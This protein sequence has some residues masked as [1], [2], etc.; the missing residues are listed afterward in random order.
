[1]IREH[2]REEESE[3]YTEESETSIS[4]LIENLQKSNESEFINKLINN[5]S[6][7]NDFNE[8]IFISMTEYILKVGKNLFL[9]EQSELFIELYLEI[10]EY[11]KNTA[12]S[13][14]KQYNIIF[15]FIDNI[16]MD[17]NINN[18]IL[19][20]IQF[21]DFFKIEIISNID[22][23]IDKILNNKRIHIIEIITYIFKWDELHEKIL[24][25]FNYLAIN[26]SNF[27]VSE[28]IDIMSLFMIDK[29]RCDFIYKNSLLV[30]NI[31]IYLDTNNNLDGII[32]HIIKHINIL[33]MPEFS[34][35]GFEEGLIWMK[36]IYNYIINSNQDTKNLAETIGF[37][38]QLFI[39]KI[40][41]VSEIP[42]EIIQICL[43]IIDIETTFSLKYNSTTFFISIILLRENI[44]EKKELFYE[45]STKICQC[46][47]ELC[48]NIYKEDMFLFISI[49]KEILELLIDIENGKEMFEEYFDNNEE[50]N[51][52]VNSLS[53]ISIDEY[54]NILTQY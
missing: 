46:F 13:I 2:E 26:I 18:I 36:Y 14:M 27:G 53:D 34:Q 11:D 47:S 21:D 19:N 29:G 25:L 50:F 12:F 44:E 10:M 37:V 3:D 40:I 43:D 22:I 33:I 45:Y 20:C 30:N 51:E 15:Y 35:S 52:I 1:M 38:K 28:I 9:N 49:T 48:D 5:C 23:I 24:N 8:Y 39:L 41:K 4:Y 7:I 17:S 16:E 31:L 32:M 6:I 54:I 42:S